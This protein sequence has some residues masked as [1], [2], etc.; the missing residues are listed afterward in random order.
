MNLIRSVCALGPIEMK[1]LQRDPLLRWLLFLPVLIAVVLRCGV[2]FARARLLE[3]LAFDLQ[4]YYPLLMSF[5]V[6]TMPLLVGFVIGFLLL[7]Q[8]D[9]RTL[10]ALQVTPL[11]LNGYL[12]YRLSAPMIASSLISLV[13]L[14]MTGLMELAYWQFFLITLAAAPIAPL[15]ALLL[16][17]IAQN[18]VQGFALSKG[19]GVILVPPLVAYFV[20][21]PWQLAYAIAPTYWPVKL[22]WLLQAG[23]P[24]W[25]VFLVAG[26]LYQGLVVWGLVKWFNKSMQSGG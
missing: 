8:R 18:K 22:Y 6:V 3:Q 7:D 4:P 11:S 19:M 24:G 26:L 2:P 21:M 15:I 14:P 5:I 25:L 20:A 9:E 17:A 16:A 23:E 12:V 1:S 10:V 13:V